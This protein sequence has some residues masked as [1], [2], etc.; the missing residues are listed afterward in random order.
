M[1]V[2]GAGRRV[3]VP[4]HWQQGAWTAA[5]VKRVQGCPMSDTDGSSW[6]QLPHCRARLSPAAEMVVPLGMGIPERAKHCS[7][8]LREKSEKMWEREL[9][10]HQGQWR[11]SR[12]RCSRH[13]SRY[14]PVACGADHDDAGC[15]P[16]AHGEPQWSKYVH[17][18]LVRTL[19]WKGWIC[20]EG[21]WS[22]WRRTHAGAREKCEREGVAEM[23]CYGVTTT[24]TPQSAWSRQPPQPI[25]PLH[26][27]GQ[28]EVEESGMK[29]WSWD[30]EE[31]SFR[32]CFSPSDS[33]FSWR[34][35]KT[36]FP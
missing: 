11:R 9:R 1:K 10:R 15:P 33:I 7:G 5:S 25:G 16:A 35:I 22:P 27:S 19:W 23:S 2:G 34:R 12:R 6:L 26:H 29:E 14:S 21:N 8:V 36:I 13:L 20:P 24:L 17:C 18:S 30:W 4:R 32:F 28:G 3:Q 31:S